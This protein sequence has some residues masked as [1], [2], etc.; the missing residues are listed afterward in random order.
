M[1]KAYFICATPRS[2]ST[3]LCELLSLTGVAGHPNEWMLEM[4]APLA[5][6]MFGIAVPFQDPSYFAA[7]RQKAI[8]PNRIF[9]AKLMWP[10]FQQLLNGGLWGLPVAQ[11]PF[12]D[13]WTFSDVGFV[14]IIREDELLQAVSMLLA[15]RTDY[16]QRME[17]P[18]RSFTPTWAEAAM[19]VDA[20]ADKRRIRTDGA[21]ARWPLD[22]VVRT[23]D[24]PIERE[25]VIAE[26]DAYRLMIRDQ[27]AAWSAFFKHH[28]ISPFEVRYETLLAEPSSTIR[29]VVAWLGLPAGQE[30]AVDQ[31]HLR[32]L[33]DE[34]NVRIA[35]A[36]AE[37][38]RG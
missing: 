30:P 9:A 36:Y 28:H 35:R 12:R 25:Q 21:I 8:T 10:T 26:V 23:L 14:R 31:L 19:R 22:E 32:A 11:P 29:D 17:A 15:I 6:E 27:N 18:S 4:L 7:L 20:R 5:E 16:W 13:A 1:T 38:R 24:D 34:R 2:G 37:D 33:S 3:M